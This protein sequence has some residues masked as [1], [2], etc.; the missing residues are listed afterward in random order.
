MSASPAGE[1]KLT[2]KYNVI[3]VDTHIIETPDIWTSRVSSKWGDLV[4]HVKRHGK[5]NRERWFIGDMR[6][7]AV[8]SLAHAGWRE[9][10]PGYPPSLEE[11]DHAS[12]DAH[13]RLKRM[14]RDGIHAQLLYPNILGF[15]SEAFMR[16]KDLELGLAC[17]QAYNDFL[18]D[19]CSAD[20]NRLIALMW[21][22][23]WNLD[24]SVAEIE[25]SAKKG[26]HGIVFGS[27]YSSIGLPPITDS[28]WDPIFAAAQDHGLSI[29]FH[30]AFSDR[31]TE[32]AKEIQTLVIKD[33]AGFAREST[34]TML[35]NATTIADIV[36]MGVCQRFPRL[37]FVSVETGAS[38]LPFVVEAMDWQW[39]NAGG[40]KAYP[41]RLLP[42]EYFRRQV[43][44][45]FWFEKSLLRNTLEMFPDNLMF[46]TDFPH[47]TSLSP[48]PASYAESPGKVI[49][50]NLTGLSE[51]ILSKVLHGNAARIYKIPGPAL[52][53]AA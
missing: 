41:E 42:S 52:R 53:M 36:L 15:Q 12:W 50:D 40:Y 16:M 22:P 34:L 24:A 26:H 37:N 23:F 51:D 9:F 48:G 43:Y 8:A 6:L 28:H 44:G 25:R 7:H 33:K 2:S 31:T 11:A 45:T 21:L 38:W 32:K 29:N 47:P 46:E 35:G 27:H 4:P 20:P 49:E 19:F 17:V 3:D 13:A 14:D 18:I 39:K 1:F 5:S 30:V 10:P